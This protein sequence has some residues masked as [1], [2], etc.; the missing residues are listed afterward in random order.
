MQTHLLQHYNKYF[1]LNVSLHDVSAFLK[2]FVKEVLSN[3]WA[4]FFPLS[5]INIKTMSLKSKL[6]QQTLVSERL[7]LPLH[8]TALLTVR[9]TVSSTVTCEIREHLK[10]TLQ[11]F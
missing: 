11:H 6:S 1:P 9:V 10:L 4:Y 3:L 2:C 7:H 8:V 5:Q